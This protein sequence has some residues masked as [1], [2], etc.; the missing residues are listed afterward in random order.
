MLY[1]ETAK[2]LLFFL[3]Q[4]L[5]IVVIVKKQSLLSPKQEGRLRSNCPMKTG[6]SVLFQGSPS[7][8]FPDSL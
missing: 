4:K 7:A 5:V 8:P 2:E 1:S 6:K 3:E